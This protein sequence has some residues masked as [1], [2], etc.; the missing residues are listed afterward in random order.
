[1]WDFLQ[2]TTE[3]NKPQTETLRTPFDEQIDYLFPTKLFPDF[4]TKSF[5]TNQTKQEEEQKIKRHKIEKIPKINAMEKMQKI[6]NINKTE[7]L[8]KLEKTETQIL[9]RKKSREIKK[10]KEKVIQQFLLSG[11]NHSESISRENPSFGAVVYRYLKSNVKNH[12]KKSSKTPKYRL[13]PTA[14]TDEIS[15]GRCSRDL[16]KWIYKKKYLHKVF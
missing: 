13:K 10:Q 14:L 7:K 2:P 16:A 4:Q 1:M 9:D 8:E 3:K 5:D 11:L 12:N 6:E 15:K